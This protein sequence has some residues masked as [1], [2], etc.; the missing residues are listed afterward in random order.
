MLVISN[1]NA[2]D[3]SLFNANLCYFC[4]DFWS[5]YIMLMLRDFRKWSEK[6]D[7]DHIV[8]GNNPR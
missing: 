5:L 1:S 3:L 7:V 8:S 4:F 6:W 2:I